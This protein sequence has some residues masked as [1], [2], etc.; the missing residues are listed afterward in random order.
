MSVAR[1]I[2]DQRTFYRVPYAVCCVILGVSTSWFYKWRNRPATGRQ[3]RRAEVDAEVRARF[4]ASQR[5]YGSPR[6]HADLVQAR[7]RLSVNTVADS[8]RRQGL[9]GRKPKCRRTHRMT[10]LATL[11]AWMGIARSRLPVP[12]RGRCQRGARAAQRA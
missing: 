5:T 12:G 9:Q 1:F 6:I 8:M 3:Q 10:T 4:V 11:K 7:W 2:A